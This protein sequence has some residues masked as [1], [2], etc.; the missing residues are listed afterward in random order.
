MIVLAYGTSFALPW[1]Y[2]AAGLAGAAVCTL[3]EAASV[4]LHVDDNLSIPFSMALTMWCFAK[5]FDAQHLPSF[6]S[7]LP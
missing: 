1:T 4:R 2:L 6:L 7:V 3:V 5:L